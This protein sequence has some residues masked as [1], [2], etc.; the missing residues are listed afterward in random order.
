MKG[1]LVLFCKCLST[2]LGSGGSGELPSP[3]SHTHTHHILMTGAPPGLDKFAFL[4]VSARLNVCNSPKD[5]GSMA[6][7]S[8]P[9]TSEESAHRSAESTRKLGPSQRV[10][11]LK[12]PSLCPPTLVGME[13]G[14][15]SSAKVPI[16]PQLLP[17]V[18]VCAL[19][20]G[21]GDLYDSVSDP[22][23]KQN[24][25]GEPRL[26]NWA[27]RLLNRRPGP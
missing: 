24:W 13:N 16:T 14:G 1:K 8:L 3:F 7:V 11:E 10:F 9:L 2:H 4:L 5:F 25:V 23:S 6:H 19:E 27:K 20:G 26:F 21:I 18:G 15:H 12:S 17:S 22:W